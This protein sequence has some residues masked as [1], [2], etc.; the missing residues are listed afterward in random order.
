MLFLPSTL[1]MA[2]GGTVPGLAQSALP[3]FKNTSR[4]GVIISLSTSIRASGNPH[5]V[6]QIPVC[7]RLPLLTPN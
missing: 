7:S 3:L 2:K 6:L 1:L 5:A 4:Y